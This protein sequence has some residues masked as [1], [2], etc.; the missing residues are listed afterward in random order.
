MEEIIEILME[1]EDWDWDD[2]DDRGQPRKIRHTI[3]GSV[4][5]RFHVF[6]VVYVDEFIHFFRS[7]PGIRKI[8]IWSMWIAP[9][10]L[11]FASLVW[12]AYSTWINLQ[13]RQGSCVV[14]KLPREYS[15]VASI[16][17]LVEGNY[18]VRRTVPNTPERTEGFVQQPCHVVVPCDTMD[19]GKTSRPED[20]RCVIF[21]SWKWGEEIDC[22]FHQDDVYGDQQKELFC[23]DLPNDMQKEG[24]TVVVAAGQLI[25]FVTVNLF[26]RWRLTQEVEKDQ[27]AIDEEEERAEELAEAKRIIEERDQRDNE[28]GMN[29]EESSSSSSSDDSD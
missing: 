24:F 5:R 22:F 17:D 29:K 16:S 1:E 27:A 3:P 4:R 28:D 19:Y 9:F 18:T 8:C 7:L 10:L 2:L 6:M 26:I 25:L 23:V 20:D 12:V 14:E 15:S 21:Q 13:Y 11:F